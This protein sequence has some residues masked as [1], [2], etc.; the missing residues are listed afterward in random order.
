MI[1][2]VEVRELT[3]GDLWYIYPRIHNYMPEVSYV[4]GLIMK[5]EGTRFE[6]IYDMELSF[7][8]P[9]SEFIPELVVSRDV[10]RLWVAAGIPVIEGGRVTAIRIT[11][12][13]EL[14]AAMPGWTIPLLVGGLL[15]AGVLAY[16]LAKKKKPALPRPLKPSP[17]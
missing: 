15:G 8:N 2:I 13:R 6:D 1:R 10:G 11:D 3:R 16:A 9:C 4:V 17:E 14:G 5:P 7:L 12:K